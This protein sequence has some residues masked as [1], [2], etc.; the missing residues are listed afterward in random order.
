MKPSFSGYAE[1]KENVNSRSKTMP[2][3]EEKN[4]MI[5]SKQNEEN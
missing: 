5:E 4:A 1:Q 2:A 3:H